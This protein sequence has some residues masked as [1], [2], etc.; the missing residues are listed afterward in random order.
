MSGTFSVVLVFTCLTIVSARDLS[1]YGS[2]RMSV[3]SVRA[4]HSTR[5]PLSYLLQYLHSQLRRNRP[6]RDQLIQRVGQRHSDADTHPH[7][8]IQGL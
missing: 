6:A 2:R 8:N 4:P 7:V 5:Q 3:H 1:N